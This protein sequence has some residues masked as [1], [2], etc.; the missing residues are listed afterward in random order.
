[1]ETEMFIQVSLRRHQLILFS[2]KIPRRCS[3]IEIYR[4]S[5]IA[6]SSYRLFALIK[7]IQEDFGA[8][9]SVI[10]DKHDDLFI[11]SHT[12]LRFMTETAKS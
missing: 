7:F 10:V 2:E 4:N 12:Y 1:M 3:G 11:G 6:Y 9:K 5:F 8:I